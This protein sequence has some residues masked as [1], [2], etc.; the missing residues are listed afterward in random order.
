MAGSGERGSMLTTRGTAGGFSAPTGALLSVVWWIVQSPASTVK[1]EVPGRKSA[2]VLVVLH[3]RPSAHW[4]LE[5]V[6]FQR[7]S[8]RG[9][10]S[11]MSVFSAIKRSWAVFTI[12][13]ALPLA[14]ATGE[15]CGGSNNAN[16]NGFAGLEAGS[17]TGGSS[18]GSSG[19]GAEG[20]SG[21]GDSGGK[22]SGPAGKCRAGGAAC[23]AYTDC[24]SM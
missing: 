17:D 12:L 4:L 16:G 3:C 20:G 18:G 9:E 6:S 5:A 13:A 14:A 15:G 24:C 22:D 19:S 23:S 8:R 1:R 2:I 7:D 10:V 21:G 11:K